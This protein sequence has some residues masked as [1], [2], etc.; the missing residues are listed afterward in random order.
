VMAGLWSAEVLHVLRI[1]RATFD[2]LCPDP[3]DALFAWLD[4]HHPQPGMTSGFVLLDPA[5]PLGSRSR[6]IVPLSGAVNV[7]PRY[8]GY[9][10][11]AAVLRRAE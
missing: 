5:V 6:T 11:A 2:A 7:R 3:P 8:R 4:G 10:D 9:A 1:R